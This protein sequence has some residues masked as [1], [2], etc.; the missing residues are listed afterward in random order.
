MAVLLLVSGCYQ[1]QPPPK[2]V[3]HPDRS[4]ASI[5]DRPI[6]EG[7]DLVMGLS[8]EPDALDPTTSSS[9]YTR[10]VMS[11]ICEKLYDID[12][13]G[14][15][16]PQLAAELPTL[17]DGGRRVSIPLREG[18]EFAD[19]TPFD[20]SA[21]KRTLQRHLNK[22]DSARASE[23]GPVSS[24]ET[25]SSHEIVLEY[26]K[27]FA[28]IT[29]ALADRAGMIMSPEAL[30]RLGDDFAQSP[31]CVG[32]F[33]FVDRVPQTSITVERDPNYYAADE[34]HLDTIKYRIMTDGNIRA[35]NL[36][37]G[38][39]QV[40]GTVSPQD[41]DALEREAGIGALQT[42]SVGYQGVTFSV[43]NV[44]GIGEP[45]GK[46]DT[47]VGNDPRIRQAFEYSID[48]DALVNSVFN[49]L[50]EPACS[51]ISPDSEFATP[52]SDECPPYDP[53]RSRELLEQAGVE[54]PLRLKMIVANTPDSLRFG[55][56][57]QA[58][59]KDGG[60]DVEL[61]PMEYTTLLDTQD[62]GDFESL[63]LGWS[64]RID[65]HGNMT[66]FLATGESNNVAGY[67]S[68]RVDELLVRAAR[69]TDPDQRAKTYGKAVSLV[70]EDDPIVYLYRQRNLTAYRED[71][72]GIA[73]YADGV[74]RL[75]RAAFLKES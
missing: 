28:P 37:S 48:R 71:V 20:A 51:P 43:G 62:R 57:L 6:R 56:A 64:G 42:G 33:K 65:P 25:P 22:D 4:T 13:S 31:V 3:E 15:L 16:V 1:V 70:H 17:R 68:K 12:E 46:V 50:F 9:L 58:A 14:S 74:V 75:S 60:F 49:N 44:N 24:I 61:V 45:P 26:A 35:P 67:S 52:A 73:T 69:Q 72:A 27:P 41:G 38:D 34:V 7:G 2:D 47:A 39:V 55:Q 23:M 18:V 8:A 5:D 54:T 29:A 30:D 10:Y 11:S 40:I 63:Q 32:P 21:V 66:T 19:G 36:R 53:E 59:V